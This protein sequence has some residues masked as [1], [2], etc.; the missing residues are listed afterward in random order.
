SVITTPNQH[1]VPKFAVAR[2]EIT[3]FTDGRWGYHEYSRWPQLYA[4][5]HI[6]VACIPRQSSPFAPSAPIVWR[7]WERGD[8]NAKECGVPRFGQLLRSLVAELDAAAESVIA[9]VARV[10]HESPNVRRM[11]HFLTVCLRHCVD[12]L[13]LL[14]SERSVII[15]LAAHAQRLILELAGLEVYASVVSHRIQAQADCRRDVLNVVGAL[16]GD[17]GIVQTLHWAGVPVWFQQPLTK[18]VSIWSVVCNADVPVLFSKV[19]SYPRL[20]LATRDSSGSLNIPGEWQVAME[21]TVRRQLCSSRLPTLLIE[22]SPR[23][24]PSKRTRHGTCGA[25]SWSSAAGPSTSS[26]VRPDAS[27]KSYVMNPFRHH[28]PSSSVQHSPAWA[29]ALR[30]VSPLPQPRSS[31]TYFFPPPWMIDDL[32]GYEVKGDKVARYIHHFLTIRTFCRTRLFDHTI[33]GRPLTI[34]EWRDALWGD[35]ALDDPL[36]SAACREHDSRSEARHRLKQN[37]RA[38]FGKLASLPSYDPSATPVHG[39]AVVT[40]SMAATDNQLRR[41]LVWEAHETNWRCE[42]MALDAVMVGSS[43]WPEVE[44]WTRESHV[45]E[46]WGPSRSGLALCPEPEDTVP[47]CWNEPPNAGWES[48]R[49]HLQ[50]FVDLLVRWPGCPADLS[51][52]RAAVGQLNEEQYGRAL[53]LAVEFYVGTF[54]S[55][56]DRLPTPPVQESSAPIS[57]AE[58]C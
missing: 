6:H 53:A 4:H 57:P 45:S 7:T 33:A 54:A 28:Y 13:R 25:A 8:W 50:A 31:V 34:S 40:Q 15:A 51:R 23:S 29:R 11:H 22:E 39:A 27:R 52:V 32:I 49:V 58:T 35:Y 18:D 46:V 24:P 30:A 16:S 2:D 44:R 21:A 41:R 47:F 1:F 5:S 38:L 37:L 55:K 10:T 12:R 48:S 17:A 9:S 36:G 20:V 42:L 3:T 26:L 14:P 19:P 56:F 43:S